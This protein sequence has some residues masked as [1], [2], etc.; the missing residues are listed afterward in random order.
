MTGI[1]KR[2][3]GGGGSK[4]K[5]LPCGGM[6]NFWNHTMQFFSLLMAPLPLSFLYLLVFLGTDLPNGN[7]N[8]GKDPYVWGEVPSP[9][10]PFPSYGKINTSSRV[11]KHW[12][13]LTSPSGETF[14]QWV[15]VR[16]TNYA[17][18]WIESYSVDSAIHLFNNWDQG[19]S[20]LEAEVST[21]LSTLPNN[22][23]D[24]RDWTVSF[25]LQIRVWYLPHNRQ[26]CYFL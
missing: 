25:G 10:Y 23:G 13:A 15:S 19:W 5:S 11:L 7:E 6:D 20:L 14:I 4:E 1:S 12:I 17:I 21:L 9:L 24:S 26:N 16:E 3:G 2:V 18:Q 8:G 22:L